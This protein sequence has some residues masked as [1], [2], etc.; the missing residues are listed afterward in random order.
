MKKLF[1]LLLVVVVGTC[2]WFAFGLWTGIYSIYSYP[3]SKEHPDGAT[4]IVSRAEWEPMFNSPE[5]Q[6]PKREPKPQGTYSFE[7]ARVAPR[8][9]SA[10]TIVELP[11]IECA[12]KKSI[13]LQKSE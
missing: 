1:V 4:L 8:P 12:Y 9:I 6:P 2:I 10:R 11:Y 7:R 5:Y 13:Q 3:P